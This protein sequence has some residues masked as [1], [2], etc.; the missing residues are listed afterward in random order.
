MR[1]NEG[2][3]TKGFLELGINDLVFDLCFAAILRV[4]RWNSSM[5][6][7]RTCRA[8]LGHH[9]RAGNTHSRIANRRKD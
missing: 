3:R 5:F 1:S 7:F 8:L 2:F 6:A 4:F 9:I